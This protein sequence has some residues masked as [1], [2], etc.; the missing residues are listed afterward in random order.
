[1]PYRVHTILEKQSLTHILCYGSLW[2]Q[3]RMSKLFPWSFKA[4][5][6]IFNNE[7]AAID[8]GHFYSRFH[9]DFL[10]LRYFSSD[11]VYI[12]EDIHNSYPLV[13]IFV[14]EKDE[15]VFKKKN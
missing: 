6:C 8:E 11:A 3:I 2:G 7:V 4:Q 9:R 15:E 1:M 14:F 10:R 5:F 12:V 13:E